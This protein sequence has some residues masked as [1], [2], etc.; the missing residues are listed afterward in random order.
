VDNPSRAA[1]ELA[2][3]AHDPLRRVAWSWNIGG[4]KTNNHY[5]HQ[6]SDVWSYTTEEEYRNAKPNRQ[7]MLDHIGRIMETDL[8]E[9]LSDNQRCNHCQAGNGSSGY[10]CWVYSS[11]GAKQVM[12][13]GSICARCRWNTMK[14]SLSTRKL[15]REPA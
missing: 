1:F 8:G 7:K 12:Y 14:C 3:V 6:H 13:P 9:R 2:Q 10:E 4:K 5:V 11:D 15:Q